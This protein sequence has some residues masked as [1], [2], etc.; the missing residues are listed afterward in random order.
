MTNP[1][2]NAQLHTLPT[3]IVSH[4]ILMLLGKNESW[5]LG[6]LQLAAAG[7]AAR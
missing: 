2:R 1:A 3:H 4:L 6:V 5:S 7:Q